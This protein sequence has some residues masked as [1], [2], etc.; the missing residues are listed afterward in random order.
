[1]RPRLLK[2]IALA[3]AFIMLAAA[4]AIRSPRMMA[5]HASSEQQSSAVVFAVSGTN[6]PNASMEPFL[7][8]EN[9]AYKQPVAGDSDA[10][11]ISKFSDQY[12]RRGQKYRVLFGGGDAG[13]AT[14]KAS[15]KDNECSRTS[16]D[17][18]LQTQARLNSNVMALATNSD[19]LG[20][21]KGSRRAPTDTERA[22]ALALA[23]TA[24][25]QKGVA[26]ALLPS[27]TVIN[28]TALDLDRDG[29]SELIG[30]FVVKKT[31]GG[32]ARHMLFL[33]AEPQGANFK[34]AIAEYD[35]I[36]AKSIMS[37]STITAIEQAG[38]YVERLLDQLDLDGDGTGEV[39]TITTG[40]EGVG[41]NIH[42]KSQG[43]WAKVYEFSNYQCAF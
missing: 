41:Y 24:F 7:I 35:Q 29:K 17:V 19:S 39:L 2:F 12:Y 28:L 37:G 11:E 5:A 3:A 14:V 9:G 22:S 26:A 4:L 1:M 21:G 20:T 13:T 8:I 40:L 30:S 43:K 15:G 6:L 42:K 31:K 23:Q 18:T 27:L 25:R 34:T 10:A 32:Q 36:D 33:L 16:A 38:I